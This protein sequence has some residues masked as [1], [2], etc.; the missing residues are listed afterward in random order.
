MTF[1]VSFGVKN[2]WRLKVQFLWD[3]EAGVGRMVIIK[4]SHFEHELAR[5]FI[6]FN[7]VVEPK[8]PQLI[9]LLE[10]AWRCQLFP[11]FDS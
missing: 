11:E 6:D 4:A 3:E 7:P 10:P 2:Y 1:L 5:F 9:D 8:S